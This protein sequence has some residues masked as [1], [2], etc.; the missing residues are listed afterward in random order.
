MI[1]QS[2]APRVKRE[3]LLSLSLSLSLVFL[4]LLLSAKLFL[5]LAEKARYRE[6]RL[7]Q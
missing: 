5:E 6:R 2:E 7:T 3:L 4:S 1:R